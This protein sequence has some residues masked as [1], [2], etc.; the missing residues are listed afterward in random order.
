MEE[1]PLVR[2]RIR[3][4]AGLHRVDQLIDAT[5]ARA[6]IHVVLRMLL[7]RPADAEP[8]HRSP[9][10]EDVER[11]DALREIHRTVVASHQDAGADDDLRRPARNRSQQVHGL[12]DRAV[13]LGNGKARPRRVSRLDDV[14]EEQMLL[15]EQ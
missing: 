9:A 10:G 11:R 8:E 14:G 6:W 13:G 1:L 3:S 4:P 2:N 15:H 7:V 5:P 12:K